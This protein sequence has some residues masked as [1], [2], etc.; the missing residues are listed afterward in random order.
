MRAALRHPADGT[1][2]RLTIALPLYRSA[3]FL[4]V[5]VPNLETVAAMDDVE[6]LVSDRHLLDDALERLRGRFGGDPRFRFLAAGDALGWPEHCNWLL[7]RGRGRYFAW[8]PHDDTFPPGWYDGLCAHLDARPETLL[9]FGPLF[10]LDEAG[11][12]PPWTKPLHAAPAWSRTECWTQ[13]DAFR[14]LGFHP[15]VP[16]RG[17][18]RRDAVIEAGLALR[19][20]PGDA[21][22]D[23]VWLFGAGLLGAIRFV[24]VPGCTKRLYA[25]ST[26]SGFRFTFGV[27]SGIHAGFARH[28]LRYS[29]SPGTLL[30]LLAA[31]GWRYLTKAVFPGLARR[32]RRLDPAQS[33]RAD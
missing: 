26:G 24:E 7:E 17:V 28:A 16:F 13:F 3:R 22:A 11:E 27:L 31:L 5:I 21:A 29:K 1:N 33:H 19:A 18:F 20:T 12:E 8:M 32:I 25:G 4:T 2:P 10:G 23:T 9:A 6:V 15:W 14:M 30:R